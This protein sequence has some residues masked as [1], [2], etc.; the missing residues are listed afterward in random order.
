MIASFDRPGE[1]KEIYFALSN[2]FQLANPLI[3]KTYKIAGLYAIY[4][5]DIC[6]YAGQSKNIPSRL[7]T[8]LTGRYNIADRVDVY[9]ICQDAFSDFYERSKKIQTIV[10]EINEKKLINLLNPTENIIVD[11]SDID[12]SYLFCS[13]SDGPC[14]P[15][16]DIQAYISDRNITV[17]DDKFH[18]HLSIDPRIESQRKA[19]STIVKEV[20]HNG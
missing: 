11:R 2:S 19:L 10:L 16:H 14:P 13:L 1:S 4:A 9:F 12:D 7:S 20:G 8:H 18:F 5:K 15:Y 3:S 6:L 17:T